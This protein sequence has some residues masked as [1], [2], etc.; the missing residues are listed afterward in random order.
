[1]AWILSLR[2]DLVDP[3]Y[4]IDRGSR[5]LGPGSGLVGLRKILARLWDKAPAWAVAGVVSALAAELAGIR[6]SDG[7]AL[8][9]RKL[10]NVLLLVEAV[11]VLVLVLVLSA[12][13][14]LVG[15][16]FA[17]FCVGVAFEITKITVL[18][19]IVVILTVLV[20]VVICVIVII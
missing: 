14:Q 16:V 20:I 19:T 13:V 8:V 11:V 1:M 18:T 2:L 7:L 12:I 17:A 5:S 6:E 4:V 15:W 3:G 9:Q 10:V